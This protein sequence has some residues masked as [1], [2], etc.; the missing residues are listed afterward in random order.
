M[1][2]YIWIGVMIMLGAFLFCVVL[3]IILLVCVILIR[4][5]TNLEYA[6]NKKKE[7]K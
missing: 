2:N 5:F 1:T 7:K 6:I 4:V 3:G